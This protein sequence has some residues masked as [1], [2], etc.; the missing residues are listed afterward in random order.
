MFVKYSQGFIVLPG[1]FGTLDELF[2]SL[3]L[4]Q[5]FKIG[6]FPIV[7]MGSDYWS[8][9]IDWI[10]KSLLEAEGNINPQDLNL[11]QVADTADEAVKIITDF[12]SKYTLKPNF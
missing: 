6:K 1:G 3:T 2:E 4:I 5:T 8:G 9:L 11:F 12:Y 10:K 7:L